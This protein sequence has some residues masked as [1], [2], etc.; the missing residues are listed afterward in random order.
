M[1]RKNRRFCIHCS[2]TMTPEEKKNTIG[3]C[4]NCDCNEAL[5]K[6][7]ADDP[8]DGLADMTMEELEKMI[9]ERYPTMPKKYSGDE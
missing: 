6:K 8:E 9:E 2:K 1:K 7:Y 3:L 4:K 5:R